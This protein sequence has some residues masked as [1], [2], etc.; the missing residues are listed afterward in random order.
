MYFLK[1]MMTTAIMMMTRKRAFFIT[2]KCEKIHNFF[3]QLF[4]VMNEARFFVGVTDTQN[5]LLTTE[6]NVRPMSQQGRPFPA[7]T[8]CT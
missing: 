7:A 1:E 6:F 5:K 2:G 8:R 4:S 3:S